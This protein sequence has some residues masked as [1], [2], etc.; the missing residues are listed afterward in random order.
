MRCLLIAN[1][2][3][4]ARRIQ[5]TARAMGI[6]TV[7]VFTETDR[8]MPFVH[9][10]DQA[11]LIGSYL[12]SDQLIAA[13]RRAGAAAI[14]PGYGFF[15]ERA[16]FAQACADGGLAFVGP[17]PSAIAAMASKP[18]ARA[19]A[20]HSEVPVLPATQDV[21]RASEIGFPLL[22]KAAA[23]GGGRGMRLV[24]SAAELPEALASAQREAQATF[25]I[26][27][28]YLE[29]YWPG[30]RHV[31][32]QIAADH[33]GNVVHI[34]EREC[35]IQ[36]RHQKLIEETPAPC[37]GDATRQRLFEAALRLA[38]AIDYTNLGTVEFLVKDDEIAFLEMNTRLQVEHPVTEAITSLDLVR[39]QLEIAAGGP[40]PFAQADLH[41]RGHAI[42]ARLYA[43]DPAHDFLPSVG[44]VHRF[45]PAD[46]R[47]R[48]DS[49]VESGVG[50]SP[51]F[52]GLLA[53]A[54][55]HAGN[56]AEA[57]SLLSVALRA[58]QVH[59]LDTN[60]DALVAMLESE[61]FGAAALSTDFLER[62]PELLTPCLPYG[63]ETRHALA[64]ELVLR[65]RRHAGA[66]VLRFVPPGWRNV[67]S[68]AAE[69]PYTVSSISDQHVDLQ[70]DGIQQ[71][72]WVHSFGGEHYV[73]TW[74]DQTRVCI[75]P[76]F[77][78]SAEG[79]A[80]AAGPTAHLP[81]TVRAVL[82]QPGER[83]RPGQTLVVLDAM[84][85]EHHVTADAEAQ[86]AEV[87]VEPGQKVDA[88]QVL[89]VL[90]P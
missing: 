82:V 28:V 25:G 24:D 72:Y 52:D 73:N 22:V 70:V 10:A 23:G 74:H 81:G 88:H 55:A 3:E 2:G 35:S 38:R 4:I 29:R 33:H 5:R 86:V 34:F 44:R 45:A 51:D 65:H 62:H 31:E 71:R 26:G 57:R 47:V 8:H 83:V 30:A 63:V 41:P 80:D 9:E 79:V 78:D 6:A 53:K 75:P 87:R 84:K 39:L 40:L 85:I 20:Q 60:R 68:P 36:R 56:R 69:A 14:H 50:I 77:G 90:E 48:W 54:I 32:V 13:A 11:V 12:D 66:R 37:L 61:A 1:R 18:G 43:E 64:A 21:E 49:G 89:V 76:R 46:D 17:S 67:S 15:S 16:S 27:T 42:E 19:I 59:G 7:A 58:L